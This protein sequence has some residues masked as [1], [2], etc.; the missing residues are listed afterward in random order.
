MAN[1]DSVFKK[2]IRNLKR[3]DE[4][5]AEEF[6]DEF[7]VRV[8]RRTPNPPTANPL[9]PSPSTGKLRRAWTSEVKGND[10]LIENLTEYAGYVE[11]GTEKMNGM[12]MAKTTISETPQISK[13]AL[14]RSKRKIK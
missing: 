1:N 11:D 9:A 12:H 2:I 10:I 4:D 14:K 3:T 13:L 7:I 8:K 6:A 5:F